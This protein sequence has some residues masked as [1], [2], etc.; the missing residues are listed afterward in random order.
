[1]TGRSRLFLNLLHA[2]QLAEHLPD[3][4]MAGNRFQGDPFC[5]DIIQPPTG[6]KSTVARECLILLQVIGTPVPDFSP[7]RRDIHLWLPP[8]ITTH[9]L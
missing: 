8:S 4:R 7:A 6:S 1:M 3:N 2:T 5:Q 9:Q